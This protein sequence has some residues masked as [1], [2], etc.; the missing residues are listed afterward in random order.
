MRAI[1]RA[2]TKLP[3][4]GDRPDEMQRITSNEDLINSIEI[5][6]GSC[7]PIMVQVQLS[8]DGGEAV[9]TTPTND[10]DLFAE[11]QFDTTNKTYD[12]LVSDSDNQLYVIGGKTKAK[13]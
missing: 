8:R 7:Q 1:Y 10:R 3:I 4:D 5:T 6:K 11:D 12:P 9:Q 13:A 2:I